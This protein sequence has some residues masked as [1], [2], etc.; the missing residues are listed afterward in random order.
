MPPD[1]APK[2]SIATPRSS[3]SAAGCSGRVTGLAGCSS[4]AVAGLDMDGSRYASPSFSCNDRHMLRG[5]E[6]RTTRIIRI[7]AF[8]ARIL[9]WLPP[10]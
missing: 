6:H 8:M 2:I 1:I 9:V 7:R 5:K 10:F 3:D 4:E